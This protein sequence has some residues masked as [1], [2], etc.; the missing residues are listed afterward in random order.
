MFTDKSPSGNIELS[1][2]SAILCYSSDWSFWGVFCVTIPSGW[3]WPRSFGLAQTAAPFVCQ[4][5]L[6]LYTS[7]CDSGIWDADN[8]WFDTHWE[9]ASSSRLYLKDYKQVRQPSQI[10]IKIKR[11]WNYDRSQSLGLTLFSPLDPN[12]SLVHPKHLPK[13]FPEVQLCL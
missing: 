6:G 1:C 3:G 5:P 4:V 8:L 13:H 12:L 2:S 9:A 7:M 11:C 10:R